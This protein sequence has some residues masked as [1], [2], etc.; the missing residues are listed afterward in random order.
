MLD[1]SFEFEA[2]SFARRKV[3]AFDTPEMFAVYRELM[4]IAKEIESCRASI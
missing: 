1:Q 2:P 4:V 3:Y